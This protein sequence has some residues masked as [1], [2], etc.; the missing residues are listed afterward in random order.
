M[1]FSC[2]SGSTRVG[3]Q[4]RRHQL[5]TEVPAGISRTDSLG[6]PPTHVAWLGIG[7]GG[8]LPC[9]HLSRTFFLPPPVYL[10]ISSSKGLEGKQLPLS[11]LSNVSNPNDWELSLEYGVLNSHFFLARIITTNSRTTGN[12]PLFST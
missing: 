9:C 1:L 2:P 5:G 6:S 8:H 12:V 10:F 7:P 4:V 3:R 11:N